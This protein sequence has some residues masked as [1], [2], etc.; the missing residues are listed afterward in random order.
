MASSVLKQPQVKTLLKTY[1]NEYTIPSVGYTTLDSSTDLSAKTI[2]GMVV[3]YW[4]SSTGAFS[5]GL[6]SDNRVYIYG[7]PNVKVKNLIVRYAY[8]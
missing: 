7:T 2:I 3:T 8:I 5:L 1:S 6:G 4:A